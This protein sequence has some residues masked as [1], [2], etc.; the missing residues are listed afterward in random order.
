M[1]LKMGNGFVRTWLLG[2][3]SR[4]QEGGSQRKL[5]I[6]PEQPPGMGLKYRH[7]KETLDDLQGIQ[8]FHGYFKSDNMHYDY[9]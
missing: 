9:L 4:F 1:L 3:S 5:S 6:A 8:F 7:V 2:L